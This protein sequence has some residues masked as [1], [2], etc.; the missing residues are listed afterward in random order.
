MA[1]FP[2]QKAALSRGIWK[3]AV[4]SQA[5]Y[6]MV[7]STIEHSY[8]FITPNPELQWL[9]CWVFSLFCHLC[10]IHFFL[11]KKASSLPEHCS[12]LETKPPSPLLVGKTNFSEWF[13]EAFSLT[14]IEMRGEKHPTL[15]HGDGLLP[16]NTNTTSQVRKTTLKILFPPHHL[17]C[18]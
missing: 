5:L 16:V 17:P 9:H 7:T 3:T 4:S 18:A 8:S 2:C 10:G 14:W 13:F 12:S 6:P 11:T 1:G 15:S